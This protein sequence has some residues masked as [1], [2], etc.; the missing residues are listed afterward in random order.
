MPNGK[1]E[2]GHDLDQSLSEDLREISGPTHSLPPECLFVL[3]HWNSEK[4]GTV[5]GYPW[6]PKD[7]SP[8]VGIVLWSTPHEPAW[9]PVCLC[10]PLAYTEVY[11]LGRL[12]IEMLLNVHSLVPFQPLMY[13]S[14]YLQMPLI[15]NNDI[16]LFLKA[17]SSPELESDS[18]RNLGGF[19]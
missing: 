6:G 15:L 16:I 17:E 10:D 12:H 3:I 7:L 13:V 18:Q 4:A 19:G 2:G 5:G 11:Q 8:S 1:P 14:E 9:Q